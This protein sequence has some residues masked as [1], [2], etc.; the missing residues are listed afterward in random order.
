MTQR[1]SGRYQ[2]LLAAIL[3]MPAAS[4]AASPSCPGDKTM[5]SQEP[6]VTIV[7]DGSGNRRTTVQND[8]E[9]TIRLEQHG[10]DHAA[11][12]V[13]S[14]SGSKLDISQSGASARADVVQG[15]A[16][17]AARLSQSGSGNR[18]TIV[19]SGGGNH[20]VVRQGPAKGDGQ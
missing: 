2:A 4:V 15:G 3:A 20:A 8:P 18:A 17:N 11:L 5:Q 16:C 19:Q 7:T 12:A 6:G 10:K 14:G 9:G 13:Q 1:Q